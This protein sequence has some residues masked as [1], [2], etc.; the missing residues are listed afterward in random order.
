MAVVL[1]F[2]TTTVFEIITEEGREDSYYLDLVAKFAHFVFVQVSALVCALIATAF[3][4]FL[5]SFLTLSAL[6]YAIG[7]GAMTALALFEVAVFYNKS[8][9]PDGE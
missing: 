3:P 1:P 8:Q 2:P 5:F 7:T 9:S 6:F 4:F